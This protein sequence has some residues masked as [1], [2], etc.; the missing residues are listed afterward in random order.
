LPLA[1]AYEISCSSEATLRVASLPMGLISSVGFL[2]FQLCSEAIIK[3]FDF[4]NG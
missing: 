2:R 3:I 4:Y 1:F